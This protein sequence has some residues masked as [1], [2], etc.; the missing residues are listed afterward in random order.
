MNPPVPPRVLRRVLRDPIWPL[1][2]VLAMIGLGILTIP[3]ILLAAF[4]RR[5]R[6]I[7][8]ARMALASLALELRM[9]CGCWLLWLRMPPWRRDPVRWRAEHLALLEHRL[10][11]F[12]TVAERSVGLRVDSQVP[13][14]SPAAAQAPLLVLARHIGPGDTFLVV[15]QVLARQRRA[16]RVV[17]KR[18]LLW[19]GAMDLML[20][21]L[22]CHFLPPRRVDERRRT[23]LLA[24]FAASAGPGDAIVIFPEGGNFSPRRH[25]ASMEWAAA[26]GDAALGRWLLDHPRVLPPRAKGSSQLL[27]ANPQLRPVVMAHFG[28]D[29]LGTPAEILAGLPLHRPVVVAAREVPRPAELSTEAVEDW[30]QGLWSRIDARAAAEA[31]ALLALPSPD[32][33]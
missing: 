2:L 33:A 30:L 9:F 17:L 15:H 23:Q 28:L 8:I 7:R 16:P 12:L 24:E 31:D 6:G 27:R 21:R 25:A 11:V 19:D 13:A 20:G 18:A 26:H 10:E 4:D 22:G 29:H 3:L 32:E 5:R 1:L 14:P